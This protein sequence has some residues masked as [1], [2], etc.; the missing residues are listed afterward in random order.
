M[1]IP[2]IDELKKCVEML[3]CLTKD[4]SPEKYKDCPDVLKAFKTSLS[5][6]SLV[7]NV[8]EKMGEMKEEVYM[9][10]FKCGGCGVCPACEHYKKYGDYEKN[11]QNAGYNLARTEDILTF[12]KWMMGLQD[13]VKNMKDLDPKYAKLINENFWDLI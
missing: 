11:I 9:E 6:A 12:T 13:M 1:D 2:N 8:S 10:D 7:I 5:L 3:T 4:F